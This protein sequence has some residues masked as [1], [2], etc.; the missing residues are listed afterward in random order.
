MFVVK[1]KA[2]LRFGA[3]AFS[4]L[5]Y[6]VVRA[7][8]VKPRVTCIYRLADLPVWRVDEAGHAHFDASILISQLKSEVDP[9]KWVSGEAEL[10]EMEDNKGLAVAATTDLHRK[11][12]HFLGR[13]IAFANHDVQQRLKDNLEKALLANQR[14][15]VFAADPSSK[16]TDEFFDA[17]G[18]LSSPE[19]EAVLR[20]YVIQCV[21]PSQAAE[22]PYWKEPP[23]SSSPRIAILR[24]D[25]SVVAISNFADFRRNDALDNEALAKFLQLH[26]ES[27]PD[28]IAELETALAKA[29]KEEKCVLVQMSGPNCGPCVELSRYFENQAALISKDY[30][31]IKLDQRMAHSADLTKK[32]ANGTEYIPWMAFL[33]DGGE[34]LANSVSNEGNIGFPSGDAAQAH[35]KKM[36][37]VSRKRLSDAEVDS[38]IDAIP[39]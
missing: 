22:L 26:S 16:A 1:W 19:L 21:T 17:Q 2:A 14:I 39:K 23:A 29:A 37:E 33:S 38:L 5:N 20:N 6:H 34:S 13:K 10:A 28:A 12:K 30:V 25:R 8:D 4:L 15:L 11:V 35:F 32:Y 18:E 9:E 31:Y 36:L 27:F 7:D 24:P 3:I